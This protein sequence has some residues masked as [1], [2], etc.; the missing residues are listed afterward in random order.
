MVR[1]GNGQD[2]SCN[3]KVLSRTRKLILS[4]LGV[5]WDRHASIFTVIWDRN[6]I[7]DYMDN[8]NLI[9]CAD[10]DRKMNIVCC[11][12]KEKK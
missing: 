11:A 1:T 2:R 12:K 10:W 3:C 5:V 4:H 9:L 6:N 7:P 8:L